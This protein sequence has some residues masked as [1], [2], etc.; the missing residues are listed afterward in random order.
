MIDKNIDLKD[1]DNYL[2]ELLELDKNLKIKIKLLERNDP[3][4]PKDKG[5]RHCG[6][7]YFSEDKTKF[8]VIVNASR[9]L[10]IILTTICHEYLHISQITT[11]EW[12]PLP[13][14]DLWQGKCYVRSSILTEKSYPWEI[15]AY[16][17]ENLYFILLNRYL[18]R[19][20]ELH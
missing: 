12:V 20:T 11:G 13:H 15:H 3:K 1:V 18:I 5:D 7:F 19:K 2:R 16:K 6:C 4:Y 10:S 14:Y 9:P 8:E 17:N